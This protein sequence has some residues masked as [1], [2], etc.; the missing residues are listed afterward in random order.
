M[1]TKHVVVE[2]RNQRLTALEA[3]RQSISALSN[4]ASVSLNTLPMRELARKK[5][6][7]LILHDSGKQS[8]DEDRQYVGLRK[9][10]QNFL[11]L[12]VVHIGQ[13]TRGARFSDFLA[14]LSASVY[15]FT[16]HISLCGAALPKRVHVELQSR[17]VINYEELIRSR[18]P[19]DVLSPTTPSIALSAAP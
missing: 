18:V 13:N 16:M 14:F 9:R 8:L 5:Y 17:E 4:V 2:R 12:A 10:S 19:I 1:S 11:T 3:R 15:A 7:Y 6:T